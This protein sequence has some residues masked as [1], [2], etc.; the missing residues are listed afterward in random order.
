ML[1][2][3]R[4]AEQGLRLSSKQLFQQ[5]TIAGL[6]GALGEAAER[7]PRLSG[8]GRVELTPIQ[9]WYL[10]GAR[11]PEHYSQSLLL[12]VS[13]EVGTEE[14]R[15]ALMHYRA[16]FDDLLGERVERKERGAA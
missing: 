8:V 13:A 3:S 12:E 2:R 1:F 7:A 6:R 15:Q 11:R 9:R 5:Q 14:L 16:L 10:E 4:A